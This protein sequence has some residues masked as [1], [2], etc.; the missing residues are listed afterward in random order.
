MCTASCAHGLVCIHCLI[1]RMTSNK[2]TILVKSLTMLACITNQVCELSWA[3]PC[4]I[5]YNHM[6]LNTRP[7][8]ARNQ[9]VR[10]IFQYYIRPECFSFL[11]NK[12]QQDASMYLSMLKEITVHVYSSSDK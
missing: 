5:M 1:R 10:L 11:L 12:Q 4:T 2:T 6:C 9:I 3:H 7:I 8:K